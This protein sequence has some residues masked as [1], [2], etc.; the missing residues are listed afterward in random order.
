MPVRSLNNA[1]AVALII[2][3]AAAPATA[4]EETGV[5]GYWQ[6]PDGGRIEITNCG[7]K[8]CGFIRPHKS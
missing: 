4:F 7:D 5:H 2:L 8:L 1:F 3:I 6:P